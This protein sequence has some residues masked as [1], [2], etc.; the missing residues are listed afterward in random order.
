MRTRGLEGLSSMT[1]GN[2]LIMNCGDGQLE[3]CEL[4]VELIMFTGLL[5]V[6]VYV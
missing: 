6:L 5:F 2:T 4:I 1:E 3:V